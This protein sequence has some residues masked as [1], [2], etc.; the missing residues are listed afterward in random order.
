MTFAA[1][2]R[3][4]L[5][6]RGVDQTELATALGL[7]SQA[8]NQWVK[9]DGTR[10]RGKRLDAIA[11]CLDITVDDLM[12]PPGSPIPRRRGARLGKRHSEQAGE[13]V[14]E[15]EEIRRLIQLWNGMS[16]GMKEALMT[17]A[18][19]IARET[20]KSSDAA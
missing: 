13:F 2:L 10:P 5:D 17:L 3:E 18:I 19:A 8:V 7:T 14:H 1:R 20:H 16:I 11:E 15:S 12:M 6:E 4:I 9:T